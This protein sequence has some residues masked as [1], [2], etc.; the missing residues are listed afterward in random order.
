MSTVTEDI[1]RLREAGQLTKLGARMRARQQE[2]R[3][4]YLSEQALGWLKVEM[5][6]AKSDK[7]VDGAATPKDQLDT[8]TRRFCAGEDL[9]PPLPHLMRPTQDGIWRFRTA[10]LRIVGWFVERGLFIVSE[11]ELKANCDEMRDNQL[12]EAARQLRTSLN[13]NGG[14]FISGVFD[15]CI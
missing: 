5:K 1:Q 2:C 9:D 4:I 7:F 10:D 12:L 6:T 3:L 13:I 8:I 14:R 11:V 15:D